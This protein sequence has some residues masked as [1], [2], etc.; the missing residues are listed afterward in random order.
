M[1]RAKKT[2][3]EAVQF[4]PIITLAFTFII[5]GGVD[6]EQAGPLFVVA[7]IMAIGITSW[8][9]ILKVTQNPILLASNIWLLLGALAFGV[10]IPFLAT[11]F[12]Q[13]NAALLF[14]S[15]LSVGIAQTALK[16]PT[17]FIGMT[18]ADPQTVRRLS[19]IMLGLSAVILIWAVLFRDN[20]RLGG[21]LPFIVLNISRRILIKRAVSPKTTPEA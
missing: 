6:L 9:H 15:V 18:N 11:V 19:V 16:R 12:S 14:A 1:N 7:A 3:T 5:K 10:P 17:G 4:V 2:L 8:L 13:T 20:I 21:G